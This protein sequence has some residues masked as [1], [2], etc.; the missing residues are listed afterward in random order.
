[1]LQSE[2]RWQGERDA[3][4]AAHEKELQ[5]KDEELGQLRKGARVAQKHI[6]H[7]RVKLLAA[8]QKIV[9][10]TEKVQAQQTDLAKRKVAPPP[11][12]SAPPA[13]LAATVSR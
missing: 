8:E 6:E 9:S 7:L 2:A 5:S 10:L 11:A 4:R 3:L 1:M 13:R 12:P